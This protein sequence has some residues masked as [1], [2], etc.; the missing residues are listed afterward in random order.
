MEVVLKKTAVKYVQIDG[1]TPYRVQQ[2]RL[3]QFLSDPTITFLICTTRTL[4]EA[5]TLLAAFVNT[6]WSIN[7]NPEAVKQAESR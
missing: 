7:A 1:D 2:S 3:R 4:G 5:I 6:F